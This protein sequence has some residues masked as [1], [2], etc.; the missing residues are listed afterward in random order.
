MTLGSQLGDIVLVPIPFSDLSS[1]GRHHVE[2]GIHAIQLCAHPGR[3]RR[4]KPPSIVDTG[5]WFSS[6]QSLDEEWILRADARLSRSCLS[7]GA[8]TS[9]R[10]VGIFV[11]APR[12]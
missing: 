9:R 4:L 8:P 10:C 6:E 7:P 2:S 11:H 1:T 5:R 12:F 3:S